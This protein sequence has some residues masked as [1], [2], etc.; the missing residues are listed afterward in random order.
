MEARNDIRQLSC[1]GER[2]RDAYHNLAKT[3]LLSGSSAF[4]W[5][6]KQEV[7]LQGVGR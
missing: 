1:L 7:H 2:E 6:K 5:N 3:L 4:F